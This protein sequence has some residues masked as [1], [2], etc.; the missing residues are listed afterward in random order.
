M[1][2]QSNLFKSAA[3]LTMLAPMM[4]GVVAHAAED[5]PEAPSTEATEG[6]T[7]DA[8]EKEETPKAPAT[9]KASAADSKG[10]VD[11]IESTDVPDPLD[12]HNP[13]PNNPMNP[14][15]PDG[16]FAPDTDGNGNEGGDENVTHNAGPLSLDVVPNFRFG[17]RTVTANGNEKMGGYSALHM[18][19]GSEN[20]LG[21]EDIAFPHWVQITDNRDNTKNDFTLTLK[22]SGFTSEDA[23]ATKAL[24][25]ATISIA[26]LSAKSVNGN[27]ENMTLTPIT[28]STDEQT[29]VESK[30]N[31]GVKGTSEIRIGTTFEDDAEG[32]LAA[33]PKETVKD[34]DG[35]NKDVS[36]DQSIRLHLPKGVTPDNHGH[37]TDTLTWTLSSAE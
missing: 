25:G 17:T 16:P 14:K 7:E 33:L 6:V 35:N 3:M 4:G 8:P 23:T 18:T 10:T 28:I 1:K 19:K 2:I 13:D 27:E 32:K 36:V 9:G 15:D 34:K 22:D 24:T 12:P 30:G 26:D 29:I 21:G 37:Y 11:F 5:A 31:A 20:G